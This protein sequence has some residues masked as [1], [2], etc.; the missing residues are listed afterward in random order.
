MAANPGGVPSADGGPGAG[1][2]SA[3]SAFL[4]AVSFWF[5]V[6]TPKRHILRVIP[7]AKGE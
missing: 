5:P 1:C 4:V 7:P 6:A 3:E 2:D